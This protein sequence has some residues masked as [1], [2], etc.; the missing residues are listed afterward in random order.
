MIRRFILFATLVALLAS[1]LPA[2]AQSDFTW[3]VGDRGAI[4]ELGII[5]TFYTYVINTGTETDNYTVDFTVGMPQNWF[6]SLCEGDL[7]Y[8]PYPIVSEFTFTLAP[9]DTNRIGVNMTPV[10]NEGGGLA[11]VTVSS[12]NEPTRQETLDFG[13]ISDGTDVL[14]VDG[15]PDGQ[16]GPWFTDALASTG[17]VSGVWNRDGMGLLTAPDLGKFT[18]VLW[19]TGDDGTPVDANDR[20]ALRT[21]VE[22]G[23]QLY[24]GGADLAHGLGDPPS[25][26]Q[27]AW[28]QLLF[29]AKYIAADAGASSVTGVV[30]DDLG[31]GLSFAITG[32][33]GAGNNGTPDELDTAAGGTAWAEYP[34]GAVAGTRQVVDQGRAVLTGFSFEGVSLAA[35]RQTLLTAILEWLASSGPSAAGDPP[36]I[37]MT[38]PVAAPNPFNPVTT[39]TFSL[40]GATAVATVV[41]VYDVRGRQVRRLFAGS[42]APGIRSLTWNGQ[43]DNGRALPSGVYLARVR[44]DQETATVKMTLAK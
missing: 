38:R 12:H 40:G 4:T 8:A 1:A 36:A 43:D 32:G 27:L 22:G 6:S 34:G 35:E 11:V 26:P 37:L 3:E 39:I 30:G 17:L 7:C 41:D 18:T 5:H 16:P 2:A 29:G 14:I 44:T 25:I 10:T 24:M 19:S 31:D 42:L 9:G 28:L 33:D 23:G 13:V 15:D 20:D 21:Y